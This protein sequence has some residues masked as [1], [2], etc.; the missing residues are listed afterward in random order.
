MTVVLPVA[1]GD[2]LD[3]PWDDAE[4]DAL[5]IP[6]AAGS[7]RA[8]VVD[9]EPAVA[10]VLG[11]MLRQHGFEVEVAS[12]GRSANERLR[13]TLDRF[14]VVVTDLYMPE[15]NGLDVAAVARATQPRARVILMTGCSNEISTAST[16]GSVDAVLAQPFSLEEVWA[17][18]GSSN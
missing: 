6:A 7:S 13:A 17:L 18:V 12:D 16:Q 4:R 15:V 9:D 2:V 10:R 8:L 1:R 3:S 11:E 14:D 5:G